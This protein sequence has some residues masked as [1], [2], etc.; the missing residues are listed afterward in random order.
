MLE[1]Q[2]IDLLTSTLHRLLDIVHKQNAQLHQLGGVA[3]EEEL[4]DIELTCEAVGLGAR[5][6]QE[7]KDKDNGN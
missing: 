7:D 1:L 3:C 2:L 6:G 4:E 5:D